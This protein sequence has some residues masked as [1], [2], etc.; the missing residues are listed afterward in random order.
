MACP[1]LAIPAKLAIQPELFLIAIDNSRAV[2][3]AIAGYDGHR[4]WLYSVAVLRSHQR[5]GVGTAL[6]REAESRLLGLGCRKINLQIVP[7]NGAVA[8]FYRRLGYAV[9]ERVCM[10][11]VI[12]ASETA[13]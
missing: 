5:R 7:D 11:K 1:G 6:L 4:G 9:E 8:A 13:A 2:G 10:G 12:W 3:T